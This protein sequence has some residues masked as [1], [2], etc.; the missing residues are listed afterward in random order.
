MSLDLPSLRHVRIVGAGLIG[1]SIGL[2]LRKAGV[3]VTMIDSSAPAQSLASD[4]V[5][6]F[7]ET[8]KAPLPVD[9][10]LI[11]TPSSSIFEVIEQEYQLNLHSTFMD[12]SSVKVQPVLDVMK[13]SLPR[14]KFLPSHPMAGREVGGAESARSDLFQ[15]CIWAYDPSGVDEKSLK[16][17]L[18]LI[19]ACGASALA[20]S[21]DAHDHA[22]ALA[23]HLPQA[24]SSLLARQLESAP[25]AFLELAGG[26][27]RDTTRIAA[28]SPSLW[29]EIL[30]QNSEALRPLLQKVQADLALLIENLEDQD[31][32]A[33]FIEGGNRGRASIPGKH[34]GLSRAYTFLPVVIEDKPGQLAA[35]FE[36]C[37]KA[38]VNVEDLTI[39]HSPEQFTGLITLSLS[40]SDAQK[41]FDHLEG[42]GW[43][44][45]APR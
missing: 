42:Q 10:V 24:I 25:S 27:L 39:E 7:S 35:L 28:S 6:H 22:V 37:A 18:D 38:S 8:E 2:A 36:E 26:G 43:K 1:T 9:L 5:G 41:L 16:L 44:V 34:G 20:I 4:L 19:A 40:S 3:K 29:S 33:T 30:G 17:G 14:N 15:G 21:S 32:L 23:S 31:F 45:H 12:V 11:A 13:S